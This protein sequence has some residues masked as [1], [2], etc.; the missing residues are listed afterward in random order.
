MGGSP[1]FSR[2]ERDAR[3]WRRGASAERVEPLLGVRHRFRV[4]RQRWHKARKPAA[5]SSGPFTAGAKTAEPVRRPFTEPPKPSE[6]AA[7]LFEKARSAREDVLK[8][9]RLV[10]RE[11]GAA[12]GNRGG[13]SR[14]G[15]TVR[16]LGGIDF[17]NWGTARAMRGTTDPDGGAAVTNWAVASTL[18]GT[19][20]ALRGNARSKRAAIFKARG[21]VPDTRERSL[22][23]PDV[24]QDRAWDGEGS[25]TPGRAL[26]RWPPVST[27]LPGARIC[28]DEVTS[29]AEPSE[30]GG[31]FVLNK[32]P[33][34]SFYTK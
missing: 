18:R 5:P 7:E 21:T 23:A 33:L 34:E 3:T 25:A 28:L 29:S 27:C 31:H 1:G 6:T 2:E 9:F 8:P 26:S 15:G 11:R 19:A 12:R 16:A 4:D 22:A 20:P 17:R 13:E 24:D 30:G 32:E 10:R 14:L